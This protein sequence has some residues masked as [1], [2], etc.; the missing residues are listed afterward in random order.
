MYMIVSRG[1]WRACC[2]ADDSL[3]SLQLEAKSA[4]PAERAKLSQE[5]AVE[6]SNRHANRHEV[7]EIRHI[8]TCRYTYLYI[9]CKLDLLHHIY[10]QCDY[11]Y[12]CIN[13]LGAYYHIIVLIYIYMYETRG[14]RMKRGMSAA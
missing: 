6:S 4:P 12:T 2:Q 5:E 11:T 3:Q 10:I 13:T 7:I 14:R 1:T 9:Y 8:Q